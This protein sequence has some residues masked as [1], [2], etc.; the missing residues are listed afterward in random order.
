MP[1]FRLIPRASNLLGLLAVGFI[2]TASECRNDLTILPKVDPEICGDGLDNDNNGKIDC[3]DD[4]CVNVCRPDLTVTDPGQTIRADSL[5][6]TGTCTHAASITVSLE[7][8][9]SGNP[10]GMVISETAWSVMLRNLQN[11]HI[12]AT[13]V[14]VD[15]TGHLRDTATTSF[16]VQL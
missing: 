10:G 6:L 15:S 1:Y 8:P 7:P 12:T 5:E 2:F 11:G 16:D 9:L 3:R 14:A 4:E 13:A